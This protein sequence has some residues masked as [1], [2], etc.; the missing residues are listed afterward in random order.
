MGIQVEYLVPVRIQGFLDDRR[1]VGLFTADG[2]HSEGVREACTMIDVS[3]R[4]EG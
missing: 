3:V 1:G 4:S 2:G